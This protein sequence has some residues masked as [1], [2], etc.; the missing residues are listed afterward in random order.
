[1]SKVDDLLKGMDKRT[2]RYKKTKMYLECRARPG[3]VKTVKCR[4]KKDGMDA[5]VPDGEVTLTAGKCPC[6]ICGHE[7]M[8]ECMEAEGGNGC[9]CCSSICT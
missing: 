4:H 1:M 5:G 9:Y 8:W 2:A 6:S 7:W 3:Q